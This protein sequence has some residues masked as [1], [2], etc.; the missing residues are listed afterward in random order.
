MENNKFG[1]YGLTSE[2]INLLEKIAKTNKVDTWF[3][4]SKEGNFR[5]LEKGKEISG[6]NAMSSF[7]DALLFDDFKTLTD[8]EKFALLN[9]TGKVL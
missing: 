7:I 1:K 9:I 2:E 4:I 8:K 5:D 6:K 3:G